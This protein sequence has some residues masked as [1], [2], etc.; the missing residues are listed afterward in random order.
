MLCMYID[1]KT[2]VFAGTW[3]CAD[4]CTTWLSLGATT[5][6]GGT[7]LVLVYIYCTDP[8][9][10][11]CGSGPFFSGSGFGSADPVFKIRIWIQI[12]VTQKRLDPT[13]SRSGSGSHLHMFF[14]FSIFLTNL[15]TLKIKDK[16]YFDET[17]F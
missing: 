1:V 12:W 8:F 17:V 2:P 9:K 3:P 5:V 11:C 6:K 14:M 10:Q 7:K 15:M 4:Q 16:K 13:G